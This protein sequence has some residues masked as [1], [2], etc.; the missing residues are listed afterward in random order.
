MTNIHLLLRGAILTASPG[1]A[2]C[3]RLILVR[4]YIL[5][6]AFF[7]VTFNRLPK[8]KWIFAGKMLGFSCCRDC[9]RVGNEY[10]RLCWQKL[11]NSL[12]EGSYCGNYYS[13]QE[14]QNFGASLFTNMFIRPSLSV[15]TRVLPFRRVQF[16]NLSFIFVLLKDNFALGYFV[17]IINLPSH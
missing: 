4:N 13:T 7:G 3:R 8:F 16:D 15:V 11:T 2:T 5:L 14:R 6:S 17:V 1:A 10:G 9:N 12:S